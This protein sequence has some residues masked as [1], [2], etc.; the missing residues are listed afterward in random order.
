MKSASMATTSTNAS[1]WWSVTGRE[2]VRRPM[3]SA[4]ATGDADRRSSVVVVLELMPH[5]ED[6]DGLGIVDLEQ[7]DVAAVP[8]RD[9]QLAKERAVAGLATREGRRPQG[10]ESGA[11]GLERLLRERQ[12][13]SFAG[14][15][16]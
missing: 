10:G 16:A 2:Y 4:F 11:D 7:R 3:A 1:I 12:V 14:E 6:R 8:E 13:T 15:L 9:D 5:G